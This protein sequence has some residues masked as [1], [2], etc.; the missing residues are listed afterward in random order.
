MRGHRDSFS[1]IPNTLV[2]MH[3]NSRN[4]LG[5]VRMCEDDFDGLRPELTPW[6]ATLFVI[7]KY[8][9]QGIARALARAAFHA[10]CAAGYSSMYLWTSSSQLAGTLYKDLGM[11]AYFF[12]KE[13]GGGPQFPANRINRME[14]ARNS[15]HTR[16][17]RTSHYH[18]KGCL[19]AEYVRC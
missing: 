14:G 8:R 13:W 2:A 16:W 3:T 10:A 6:L 1:G 12:L 4:V 15:C 5:S 9:R 19:A 7:P 18:A 17:V 11:L